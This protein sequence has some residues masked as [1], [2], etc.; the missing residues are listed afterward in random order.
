MRSL[1]YVAVAVVVLAHNS[2]VEAF[3]NADEAKHL[4]NTTPDFVADGMISSDSRKRFLRV[5]D[6]EDGDLI[7]VHEERG[8]QKVA[9]IIKKMTKMEIQD[10]QNMKKAAEILVSMKQIRVQDV[11]KAA[12]D[13]GTITKASYNALLRMANPSKSRA[14]Q[15]REKI[16]LV[17]DLYK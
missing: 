14:Q 2:V 3:T 9:G 5:T 17:K 11:L 7:T 16:R 10:K 8:K 6:P 12:L 1:F 4:S 13:R 15:S